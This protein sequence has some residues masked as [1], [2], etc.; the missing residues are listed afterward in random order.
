MNAV[1]APFSR[2]AARLRAG[3]CAAALSLLLVLLLAGCGFHLQGDYRLPQGVDALYVAYDN[4]YR[5]GEPPLVDA[6]QQR[7]RTRGVLGGPD[8]DGRLVINNIRNGGRIVSISPI[9]GD[10]AEYE[11]R[12]TVV[13][14]YIVDGKAVLSDERFTVARFYSYNDTAPLAAEAERRD[15]LMRM[16][17]Q[18]ASRILFRINHVTAAE[19]AQGG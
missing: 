7:L 19:D 4:A 17:E 14:D 9:D 2:H 10:V 13:F 18:L 12:S 5:P 3:L 16:H 8:A 6:L 1:H 11:L 15:L